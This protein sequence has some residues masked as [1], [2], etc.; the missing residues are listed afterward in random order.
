[1]S[2]AGTAD[3]CGDGH[4]AIHRRWWYTTGEVV[5]ISCIRYVSP[6]TLVLRLAHKLAFARRFLREEAIHSLIPGSVAQPCGPHDRPAGQDL[7]STGRTR[8]ILY[9]GEEVCEKVDSN[10][11]ILLCHDDVGCEL[12]AGGFAARQALWAVSAEKLLH[13][14]HTRGVTPTG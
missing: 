10:S 11:Q 9:H 6:A 13:L 2:F 5:G 7:I 12:H 8:M 14:A 1:M 3:P 4:Q